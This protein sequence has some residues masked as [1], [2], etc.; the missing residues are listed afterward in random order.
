MESAEL[1]AWS[2]IAE[3][4]PQLPPPAAVNPTSWTQPLKAWESNAL[5][6]TSQHSQPPA[7]AHCS[8]DEPPPQADDDDEKPQDL[9][10]APSTPDNP[11]PPNTTSPSPT[12]AEVEVRFDQTRKG[13]RS[14]VVNGYKFTKSRNGAF[15]RVF[16]RCSKRACRATASSDGD[17][18][19]HAN[20]AHNHS[21]PPEN[22]FFL[23]HSGRLRQRVRVSDATPRKRRLED[24]EN[25]PPPTLPLLTGLPLFMPGE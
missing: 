15:P 23:P 1:A 12:I 2:A 9:S 25:T 4:K 20:L 19:L 3:D 14:L 6:S 11:Q 8:W 16:W 7:A 13:E 24:E 17:V 21:P 22:D 10:V 18:V 5:A